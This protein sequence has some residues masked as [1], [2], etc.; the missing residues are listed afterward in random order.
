MHCVVN[1]AEH[2]E[3]RG[4]DKAPK[5][6]VKNWQQIIF[7][8]LSNSAR[9]FVYGPKFVRFEVHLTCVSSKRC[10]YAGHQV[11]THLIVSQEWVGLPDKI[12]AAYL[13]TDIS[14]APPNI[15]FKLEM[16]KIGRAQWG[17]MKTQGRNKLGAGKMHFIRS[18]S[19]HGPLP[20]GQCLYCWTDICHLH[21]VHFLS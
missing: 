16:A 3:R 19:A 4:E 7:L 15:Q 6:V 12:L 9:K 20:V 14:E 10:D 11:P 17:L 5:N 2:Q 1:L 21:S 13:Q 8:E 18:Y